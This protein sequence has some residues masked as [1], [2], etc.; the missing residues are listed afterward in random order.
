LLGKRE[1]VM[2]KEE[3]NKDEGRFAFFH[4]QLIIDDDSVFQITS[5]LLFLLYFEYLLS[6]ALKKI[7]KSF[8]FTCRND[9]IAS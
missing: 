1:W 7:F 9:S 4:V 5:Q 3:K 2:N 6:S 8:C